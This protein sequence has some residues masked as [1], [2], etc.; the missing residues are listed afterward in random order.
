MPVEQS[1]NHVEAVRLTATRRHTRTAARTTLLECGRLN[2]QMSPRAWLAVA[3]SY[4]SG[5]PVEFVGDL[6]TVV[7]QYERRIVDRVELEA[8]R[9]RPSA[10]ID[11]AASYLVINKPGSPRLRMQADVLNLTNLLNLSTSRVCSR[12]PRLD[13][14]AA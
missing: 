3:A 12:A 9:V 5:L 6:D 13:R 11:A 8:G 10:S 4:G 1:R 7:A 14:H 2:H